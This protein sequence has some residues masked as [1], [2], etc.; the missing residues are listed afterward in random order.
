MNF[1]SLL[2]FCVIGIAISLFSLLVYISLSSN[3]CSSSDD[4]FC[5]KNSFLGPPATAITVSLSVIQAICPVVF[6]NVSVY[7]SANSYSSPIG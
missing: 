5:S 7:P 2:S 1:L 4:R 3:S 6:D